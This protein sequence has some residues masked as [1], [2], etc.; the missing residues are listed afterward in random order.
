MKI[1]IRKNRFVNDAIILNEQKI[2]G[3][4][5][6]CGKKVV[7]LL[8]VLYDLDSNTLFGESQLCCHVFFVCACSCF[9]SL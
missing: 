6:S 2:R 9:V 1:G 5:F 3:L 7:S 8:C 4:E